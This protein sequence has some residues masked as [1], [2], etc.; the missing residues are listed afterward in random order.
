MCFT[1]VL[2]PLRWHSSIIVFVYQQV[3]V[4]FNGAISHNKKY[5]SSKPPSLMSSTHVLRTLFTCFPHCHG[6]ASHGAQPA[7]QRDVA[8]YRGS[9]TRRY[10]A[11]RENT[12]I[13]VGLVWYRWWW[14]RRGKLETVEL[15]FIEPAYVVEVATRA[16]TFPTSCR[17]LVVGLSILSRVQCSR[18]KKNNILRQKVRLFTSWSVYKL[19][20]FFWARKKAVFAQQPKL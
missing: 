4:S 5:C 7:R 10:C 1:C 11:C 17:G 2:A 6:W 13:T 9:L 20:I 3:V 12:H 8:D 15:F 19:G 14:Y 16:S 18:K